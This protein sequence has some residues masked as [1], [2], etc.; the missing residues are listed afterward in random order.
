MSSLSRLHTRKERLSYLE[1]ETGMSFSY[2]DTAFVDEEHAARC[3]NMIGAVSLPLGVAGPLTLH[4][5]ILSSASVSEKKKHTSPIYV[6]LATTEGALVASVNR[7]CKVS[8]EAGGMDVYVRRKGT[9]RGPVFFT[10]SLAKSHELVA[11]LHSHEKEIKKTAEAT[12]RHLQ[13]KEILPKVT[14]PYVFLRCVYDTDKAMGMNMVTIASQQIG[15]YIEQHTDASSLAVAGN[16]DIDKKPAWLN[17]IHGRGYEA[18]AEIVIPQDVVKNILKT[19]PQRIYDV[20]VGKCM[21]GSAMSGSL[22]F[23]SHFANIVAA[24]YAATGQ[25]IA[26]TVEGS[27]GITVCSLSDK[28]KISVSVYLPSLMLGTIGGGTTLKTQ[29]QAR[30]LT[31]AET[32]EDLAGVLAGGVLAGEVSL[33]SSLAAQSLA[34]SHERLGR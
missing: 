2:V 29:T 1:K 26:H 7:G 6:P 24:F 3:E 17:I 34:C 19:T 27:L 23:N 10:G 11:F 14:G 13:L 32:P 33:L 15:Q 9:S 22:G 5:S 30:A 21:I 31:Q 20:W 16:Y 28:G 4:T 25:D 8:R 12:S 18:W